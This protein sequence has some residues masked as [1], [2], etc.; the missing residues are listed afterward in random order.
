MAKNG[1]FL[2]EGRGQSSTPGS[3][4]KYLRV[5]LGYKQRKFPGFFEGRTGTAKKTLGRGWGRGM[6]KLSVRALSREPLSLI[7]NRGLGGSNDPPILRSRFVLQRRPCY[8]PC[9]PL[10]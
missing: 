7:R 1:Q 3:H 5:I 9:L 4:P 10:P 2:V 8:L 6:H